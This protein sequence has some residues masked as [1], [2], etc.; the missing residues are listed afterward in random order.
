MNGRPL[1]FAH[2]II[3][4]FHLIDYLNYVVSAV[5]L[6]GI[7]LPINYCVRVIRQSLCVHD[8]L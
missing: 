6:A 7:C 8:T 2:A 4:I 5:S 1:L 3:T